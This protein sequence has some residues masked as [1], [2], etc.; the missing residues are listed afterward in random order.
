MTWC[1]WLLIAVTFGMA[2]DTKHRERTKGWVLQA[3]L[4][5]TLVPAEVCAL[6]LLCR[7]GWGTL[8]VAASLSAGMCALHEL[9]S[10]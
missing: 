4:G 3:L 1:L 10:R 9:S 7:A 5:Q 6:G 8:L 2:Q